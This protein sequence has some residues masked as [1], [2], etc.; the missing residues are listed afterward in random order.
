MERINI[1]AGKTFP[2]TMLYNKNYEINH[3]SLLLI[4]LESSNNDIL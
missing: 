1:T 3:A 4:L 2:I